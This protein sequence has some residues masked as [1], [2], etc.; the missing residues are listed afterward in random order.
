M[1]IRGTMPAFFAGFGRI[2]RILLNLAIDGTI[3]PRTR[4]NNWRVRLNR[5]RKPAIRN[6]GPI[7]ADRR[8]SVLLPILQATCGAFRG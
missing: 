8:C 7:N 2:M 6:K 1:L 4:C 3:V 5:E